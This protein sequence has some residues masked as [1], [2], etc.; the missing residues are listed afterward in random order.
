MTDEEPSN[1]AHFACA[2]IDPQLFDFRADI[3]AK[4]M[5]TI[6]EIGLSHCHGCTAKLACLE[7]VD[8]INGFD[9]VVGG[10]V[11][12]DGKQ[13]SPGDGRYMRPAAAH[14]D[15]AGHHK[16]CRCETCSV[17]RRLARNERQM[18]EAS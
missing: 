12:R 17:R 14:G 10:I 16:S 9:G 15:T 1:R 2:G 6:A 8:P 11:W 4:L 18:V 3:G 7:L 5:L 13:I